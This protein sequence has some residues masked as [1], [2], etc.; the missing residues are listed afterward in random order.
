MMTSINTLKVQTQQICS[1][2]VN[3][4]M[5][6]SNMPITI[7]NQIF[8]LIVFTGPNLPIALYDHS[9]APLGFG[10][11]ILGGFDEATGL[12]SKI[13]HLTCYQHICKIFQMSQEMKVPRS[14]FVTIPIPDSISGCASK[15]SW[16]CSKASF[17][18]YQGYK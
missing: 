4:V 11:A 5:I 9:M 14:R 3:T 8:F 13:Y 15:F 17:I 2:R 18:L 10:Q 7:L 6:T 12:Q 16:F 1:C